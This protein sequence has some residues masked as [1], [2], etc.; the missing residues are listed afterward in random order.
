M[1]WT[2][3][4]GDGPLA[5]QHTC[6][7]QLVL[8]GGGVGSSLA[9][10]PYGYGTSSLLQLPWLSCVSLGTSSSSV[11]VG[12]P[13]LPGCSLAGSSLLPGLPGCSLPFRAG[14]SLSLSLAAP[15]LV[16]A[17]PGSF[18]CS[19]AAPCSLIVPWLL[20]GWP[21]GCSSA[22]HG[23]RSS[24]CACV[25]APPRKRTKRQQSGNPN[26]NLVC[27]SPFRC[28]GRP[29]AHEHHRNPM[30]NS[31]RKRSTPPEI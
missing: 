10:P 7:L 14:H 24:L 12:S 23:T 26:N 16:P 18:L 5:H 31:T 19:E 1:G 15:W 17:L 6:I 2:R 27:D 28:D 4:P 20:P 30:R 9:L 13:G 22:A 21:L 29:H 3:R 8:Y 11:F 25:E